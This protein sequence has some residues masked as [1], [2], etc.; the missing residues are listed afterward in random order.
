M[1][2]NKVLEYNLYLAGLVF[3]A[4]SFLGIAL[5]LFTPFEFSDIMPECAF[6]SITMIYCPGCG[7]SRAVAAFVQGHW[8]KSFIYHPFVPYCGVLYIIFMAR[9]TAA[10]FS[11]GKYNYMKFRNAYIYFG[12]A[13]IIVQFAV[14]DIMLVVYG[15]DVL[16]YV[17]GI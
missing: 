9:G 16:Q 14:K 8:I 6:K 11:R 13:I 2:Q 17:S 3:A 12:I 15:K 5:V 1:L 7:G 4:V 10:F